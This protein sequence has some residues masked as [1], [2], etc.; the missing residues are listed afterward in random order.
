MPMYRYKAIGGDGDSV[1]GALQAESQAAALRALDEQSLFPIS[2][3][4]GG[5]AVESAISGRKKKVRLRHQTAFYRQLADLLRAG[6]PLLRSLDV[7]ARQHTSA[8]L[9]EVLGDVREDVA[10]GRTLADAMAKHPNAFAELHVTMVRAGESGG[11]LEDVLSRI[12]LFSERQDELRN[13]LLG[14]LIYPCVLVLAGTTV[15]GLLLIFVVPE[16]RKHLRP[17]TFN[18]LSRMVFGVTDFLTAWY[19]FLLCA[20]GMVLVG[21][22]IY[23][24][25]ERGRIMSAR[26]QLG[27]PVV[28]QIITMVAICRFCRILG[29]LLQNGVPILQAL[30]IAK[31]SA[32]NR[33]LSGHIAAAAE[34]VRKG[35]SLSKPL[36]KSGVFPIDIVDMM[37]V[38]EESNNLDTVLVQIA[39]TNE[40]RTARAI[41]LAVRLLEPILLL[42][43]A[44]MVLCIALALLLPILT[45]TAEGMEP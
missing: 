19:P 8:V 16:L 36:G 34:N 43:M 44:G 5:G 24:K 22:H 15:V 23:F 9:T 18:V 21:F 39:E 30:E 17:E 4:E 27:A 40:A 31:D 13:K 32:G 33:V 2:I 25:T 20:A 10:S 26:A 42:I 14:S 7:L 45:M 37:A 12:A 1:T 3:E 35:E 41:D 29:T 28:G 38:A 11:F 6:V